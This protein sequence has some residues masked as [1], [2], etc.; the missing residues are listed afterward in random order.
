MTSPYPPA[1]PNPYASPP[2]PGSVPTPYPYY[3]APPEKSW[4]WLALVG[5]HL[6]AA[7]YVLCAIGL[8]VI[9]GFAVA[10]IPNDDGA[11]PAA[12]II[13]FLAAFCLALALVA[14]V[15]TIGIHLRHK[16]AWF[17]GLVMFC[18]YLPS[19]FFPMGAMGLCGLLMGGSRKEFGMG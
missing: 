4:V 6:G 18:L 13:G 9:V 5:G 16:W 17:A 15:I 11:A 7:A 2:K 3:A 19:I 12:V 8:L 14:E 1:P 10:D